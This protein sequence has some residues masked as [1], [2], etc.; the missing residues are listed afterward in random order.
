MKSKF[1]PQWYQEKEEE[2]TFIEILFYYSNIILKYFWSSLES[3]LE[4]YSSYFQFK[5]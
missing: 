3:I 2:T 5:V 4:D 1:E